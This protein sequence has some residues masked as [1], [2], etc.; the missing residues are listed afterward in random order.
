MRGPVIYRKLS[1][2]NGTTIVCPN[3]G[4]VSNQLSVSR[5]VTTFPTIVSAV[6]TYLEVPEGV[7]ARIAPGPPDPVELASVI[8]RLETIHDGASGGGCVRILY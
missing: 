3:S 1:H 6:G 5:S 7:V 2:G 8:D 4:L